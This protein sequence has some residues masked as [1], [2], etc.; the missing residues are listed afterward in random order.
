MEHGHPETARGMYE[1][2]MQLSREA[3]YSYGEGRALTNLGNLHYFQGR[4]NKTLECYDQAIRIFASLEEKRGEVQLRLNRASIS[5]NMLGNTPQLIEDAQFALEYAMRTDDPLS[6]GQALAVLAEAERQNGDYK[7][8]R[9]HLTQGIQ[10]MELGGDLWLLAQEYRTLGMLDI[11]EKRPQ[12]ALEN[13][14]HALSICRERGLTSMEAP[15]IAIR[16]LALLQ[17]GRLDEALQATSEAVSR[18]K[19]DVEQGYLLHFWHAQ[20]LQSLG[21]RQE[22]Q[23]SMQKA[24]ELLEAALAGLS[25][26]GRSMSYE[27]IPEHRAI[28]ATWQETLP[29]QVT[30]QLQPSGESG[31]TVTVTWTPFAAED[32]QVPGKVARRR[33]RLQRLL[34]E[35]QAQGAAPTH[36]DL[37]EALGV[38]LRTVER[39]M[40]E[41]GKPKHTVRQPS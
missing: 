27:N 21:R 38:G 24:Y 4:L 19:S 26:E 34:A 36:R 29:Q 17:Q 35:A 22:A 11:E 18:L 10:E 12:E 14:D 8:A 41:V 5:L 32:N 6:K 39:D 40:A 7:T 9:K 3:G 31:K 25:A 1:K 16:G 23:A 28:L 37:A 2:S 33:H 15:I 20:V 13:L 30:V